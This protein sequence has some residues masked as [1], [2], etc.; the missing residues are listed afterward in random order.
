MGLQAGTA[1]PVE[2]RTGALAGVWQH[3]QECIDPK[4]EELLSQVRGRPVQPARPQTHAGPQGWCRLGAASTG[5]PGA[6]HTSLHRPHVLPTAAVRG[7]RCCSRSDSEPLPGG[8]L[9]RM[10]TCS[11]TAPTISHQPCRPTSGPLPGSLHR[12][13]QCFSCRPLANRKPFL[14]HCLSHNSG[15]FLSFPRGAELTAAASPVGIWGSKPLAYNLLAL[16]ASPG[17]DPRCHLHPTAAACCGRHTS[18]SK[19]HW[20]QLRTPLMS[21]LL[22]GPYRTWDS[23]S[24]ICSGRWQPPEVWTQDPWCHLSPETPLFYRPSAPWPLLQRSQTF[25]RALHPS[26]SAQS[27]QPPGRCMSGSD[28]PREVEYDGFRMHRPTRASF[29]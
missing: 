2:S 1:D 14:C 4:Q 16:Y 25:C 18:Q 13:L 26:G 10:L 20:L 7:E 11:T 17:P 19:A 24:Y 29:S 27:W 6:D 23:V 5:P 12:I 21:G 22:A 3:R 9:G 28:S 15:V 8:C